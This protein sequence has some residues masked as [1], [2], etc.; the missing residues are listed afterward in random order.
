MMAELYQH[1]VVA[2]EKKKKKKKGQCKHDQ[3]PFSLK[4]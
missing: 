1:V 2:E 4:K 3:S